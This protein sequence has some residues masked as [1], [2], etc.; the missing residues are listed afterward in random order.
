M[1]TVNA[2]TSNDLE[3][4]VAHLANSP[5]DALTED[6]KQAWRRVLSVLYRED[7]SMASLIGPAGT[8]KTFLTTRLIDML[9]G[10][11]LKI[12]CTAPTHQATHVLSDIYD[13]DGLK[14]ST[15]HSA[16][17]L[18]VTRDGQGDYTLVQD[19][20]PSVQEFDLVI[21]DE[22][23]MLGRKEWNY[24]E[25]HTHGGGPKF[26]FPGDKAQLPP[27]NEL[28]SPALDQPGAQLETIVRQASENP[29]ISLSEQIRN[30]GDFNPL[31]EPRVHPDGEQGIYMIDRREAVEKAARAMEKNQTGTRF[32]AWRNKSVDKWANRVRSLR[33]PDAE[34]FAEGM[35]VLAQ[36]PYMPGEQEIFFHTSALLRVLSV[37]KTDKQLGSNG[38]SAPAWKLDLYH[39]SENRTVRNV[40]VTRGRG[41]RMLDNYTDKC[42][43]RQ[44]WD[45]LYDAKESFARLRYSAAATIHTSQ[46]DSIKN[47][48]LDLSDLQANYNPDERRA[49]AYVGVTRAESTLVLI[50]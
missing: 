25:P 13:G 47:V 24:L 5:P 36:E 40:Y 18:R 39:E 35:T 41:K 4:K 32:L 38:P 10:I 45:E 17:G 29:I 44:E 31:P 34:R 9:T 22:S 19:G 14:V 6:Q 7:Q 49:L 48:F 12:L 27:P 30:G 23:S 16:L 43:E 3:V 42:A 1:S 33:H 37:E 11:G 15:I 8:G 2:A 46:G 21:V 20:E 50:H 28:P 26:L